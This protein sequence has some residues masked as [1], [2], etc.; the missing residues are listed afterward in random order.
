MLDSDVLLRIAAQIYTNTLLHITANYYISPVLWLSG[1]A[2]DLYAE[3]PGLESHQAGHPVSK[4]M[5]N[6]CMEHVPLW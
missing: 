1:R 5:P 4:H 2:W 6:H 3:G